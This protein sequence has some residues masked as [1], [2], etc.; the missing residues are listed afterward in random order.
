M[1]EG[2]RDG[3]GTAQPAPVTLFLCGDVMTGR[4]IDQILPHP[5]SPRLHEPYLNSAVSYVDLASV[6]AAR[7][8]GRRTSPTS[9]AMAGASSRDGAGRARS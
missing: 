1:A 3:I 8:R 7:S 9:G 2:T 5:G 4:G 6:R